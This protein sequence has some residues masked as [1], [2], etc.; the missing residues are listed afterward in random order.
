MLE[1]LILAILMGVKWDLRVVLICISKMTKNV[2]YFFKGFLPL[3]SPLSRIL[4]IN[5]LFLK[6]VI[7]F[8]DV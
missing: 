4:F 8:V 1:F 2:G 7:W 5:V 6:W 3:D